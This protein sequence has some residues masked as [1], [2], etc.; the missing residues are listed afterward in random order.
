MGG[1]F[2]LL[3]VHLKVPEIDDIIGK[4]QPPAILFSKVR[5]CYSSTEK[6]RSPLAYQALGKS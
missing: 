3:R 1:E 4:T 2:K 5:Q 6:V